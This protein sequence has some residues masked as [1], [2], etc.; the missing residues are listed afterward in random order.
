ML[1]AALLAAVMVRLGMRMRDP[2]RSR[3]TVDSLRAV[4]DTE[5][6]RAREVA[7]VLRQA[8]RDLDSLRGAVREIESTGPDSA[9]W[10]SVRR[11]LRR[12]RSMIDSLRTAAAQRTRPV[13]PGLDSLRAAGEHCAAELSRCREVNDELRAVADTLGRLRNRIARLEILH[14]VRVLFVLDSYLESPGARG[15]KKLDRAREKERV[16]TDF[17][18]CAAMRGWPEYCDVA[19]RIY[20]VDAGSVYGE[21]R[22]LVKKHGLPA[23]ALYYL[24]VAEGFTPARVHPDHLAAVIERAFVRFEDEWEVCSR[25][26]AE[27][28]EYTEPFKRFVTSRRGAYDETPLWGSLR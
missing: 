18:A 28:I 9:Q 10:R 23:E 1:C 4:V 21:I 22:K 25:R 17:N 16:V 7:V 14:N 26:L 20:A 19:R 15:D 11:S 27:A 2:V 5:L 6:T 3:S 8:N 12:A 13:S 24:T